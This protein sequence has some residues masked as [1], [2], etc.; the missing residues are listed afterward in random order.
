MDIYRFY[1]YKKNIPHKLNT[2][3]IPFIKHDDCTNHRLSA[4]WNE[5]KYV[6]ENYIEKLKQHLEDGNSVE[7]APRLGEITL[8]KIKAKSFT[9]RKKSKELGR[10]YRDWETDRK[11]VV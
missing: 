4:D 3:P 8:R 10:T 9:D 6:I 11:S 2:V 5:W 7:I 1:P